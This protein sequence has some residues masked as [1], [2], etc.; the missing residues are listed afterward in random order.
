MPRPVHPPASLARAR[1]R[2]FSSR[3]MDESRERLRLQLLHGSGLLLGT[4]SRQ[5]ILPADRSQLIAETAAIFDRLPKRSSSTDKWLPADPDCVRQGSMRTDGRSLASAIST[6]LNSTTTPARVRRCPPRLRVARSLAF[7]GE[8]ARVRAAQ[9]FVVEPVAS[10]RLPRRPGRAATASSIIS[11][12]CHETR[13]VDPLPTTSARH[14]RA[15]SCWTRVLAS[16]ARACLQATMI[17]MPP[18]TS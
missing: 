9:R 12:L 4:T 14:I 1:H 7:G 10:K 17:E 3:L 2:Q 16:N 6:L 11:A 5:W 15:A 13:V 18:A 8:I